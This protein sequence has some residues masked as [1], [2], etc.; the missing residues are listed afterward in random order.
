MSTVTCESCG[1]VL[2]EGEAQLFLG[3]L[4]LDRVGLRVVWKGRMF[5]LTPQQCE[6]LALLV[7][8]AGRVVPPEAF[9]ISVLDED[10]GNDQI[11]V[12]V[13]RVRDAF[14]AVDPGFGMIETVWGRGYRW[15]MERED[16]R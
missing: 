2:D 9:F 13:K 6:M 14:L 3:D 1:A 15:R 11:R 8:R 7:R 10:R 5:A 12:Q 4:C 16:G